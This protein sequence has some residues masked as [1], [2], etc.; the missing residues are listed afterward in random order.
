MATESIKITNVQ[1]YTATGPGKADN[2][3]ITM[4]NTGTN[5]VTVTEIHVNNEAPNLLDAQFTI[6]ANTQMVA[7]IT[8]AWAYGCNYEIE[9]KTSNGNEFTYAVTAPTS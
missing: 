7:N 1:F 6:A 3:T 2:I 9:A 8:Y 4:Q 5:P